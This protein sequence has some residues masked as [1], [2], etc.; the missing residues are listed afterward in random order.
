MAG[1]PI[2]VLDIGASKVVCLVGELQD[3]DRIKVLGVGC[4]PS[5]GLR[6]S[7]VID[8]PRI[9]DSIRAAIRDTER[10]A[11]LKISG[12]YVGMAGD[13]IS[14][15]T[16]RSTVAISGTSKPIDENDVDRALIAA[17]QV[18]PPGAVTVLHRFVQSYAVDGE[19]VQKS[20]WGDGP[21][22]AAYRAIEKAVG[23]SV[24]VDEY[25]IRAIT[26]GS[27]AMGEVTVR[28]TENGEITKGRGVSTDVIEASAKAYID[29]LNRMAVRVSRLQE[30]AV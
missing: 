1:S 3:E 29:A 8:M 18:D 21:V 2:V 25:N 23:R 11:G 17:E 6:R 10:S 13:D 16:S 30:Q 15:R 9:V 24:K 14:T 28:V 12:A 4:R 19:Q 27:Q 7:V 22:D 20:A 26:S 5:L